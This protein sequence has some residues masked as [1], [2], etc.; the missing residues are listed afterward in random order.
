MM[1][2][3]QD[4]ARV[5][6]DWIVNSR[7]ERYVPVT[8]MGDLPGVLARKGLITSAQP[9]KSGWVGINV[10]NE[11]HPVSHSGEID[12]RL[13]AI[14]LVCEGTTFYNGYVPSPGKFVRSMWDAD[15]TVGDLL[16][17]VTAARASKEM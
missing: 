12:A 16:S 13:Y 5:E 17:Q 3:G 15:S 9:E 6:V 14:G 11:Y 1:I 4:G 8:E 7:S 2:H 10:D